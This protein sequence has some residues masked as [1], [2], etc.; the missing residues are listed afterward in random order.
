MPY[1]PFEK[2]FTLE[3]DT[4]LSEHTV[5]GVPCVPAATAIAMFHAAACMHL[6]RA[7]VLENIHA[8]N[9]ILVKDRVTTCLETDANDRGLSLCLRSTIPHFIA[10]AKALDGPILTDRASATSKG[11]KL[12]A[13]LYPGKEASADGVYHG[14]CFQMLERPT[15]HSAGT[16]HA[17]IDDRS[18]ADIFGNVPYSRLALW[19]DAAFQALGF[20]TFERLGIKVLPYKVGR[21]AVGSAVASNQLLVQAR[22]DSIEDGGVHGAV[23]ITMTEGGPVLSM[24]DITMAVIA[25]AAK[26]NAAAISALAPVEA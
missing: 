20:L 16:L 15:L 17:E 21:L 19:I 14:R 13:A 22:T 1:I 23:L 5:K 26:R 2:T 12:R 9:P 4:Y 24:T 6:D 18:L 25:Q 10:E 11:Q 8:R 3:H 7:P